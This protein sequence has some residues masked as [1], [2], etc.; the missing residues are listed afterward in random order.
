M[1]QGESGESVETPGRKALAYASLPRRGDRKNTV[2]GRAVSESG[3]AWCEYERTREGVR[4]PPAVLGI[5]DSRR[6]NAIERESAEGQAASLHAEDGNTGMVAAA[7][8]RRRGVAADRRRRPLLF[9]D[10]KWFRE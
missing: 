7:E 6:D 9:L 2:G 8:I 3:N 4:E 1:D 10:R 5:A